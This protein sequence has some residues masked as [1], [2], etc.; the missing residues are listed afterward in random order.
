MDKQNFDNGWVK[1]YHPTGALVTVPLSLE[2][3]LTN[4]A[5]GFLFESVNNLISCGFSV[6]APGVEAGEFVDEIGWVV[7]KNQKNERGVTPRIE[8]YLSNPDLRKKFI[9]FYLNTEEEIFAFEAACGLKLSS[10]PVYVGKDS[11]ERGADADTDKFV[12]RLPKP[13]KFVWR[14][15]P[16]YDPN[17]QDIS[18]KKPRR[19]FVRWMVAA[20]APVT[21]GTSDLEAASATVCHVGNDAS[22]RGKTLGQLIEAGRQDVINFLA[23]DFAANDDAGKKLKNAAIL[24]KRHAEQ[25]QNLSTLGF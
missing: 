12:A 10:L 1:L 7:R 4:A 15:N 22:V 25:K 24:L 11:V 5:A 20:T 17:E 23:D 9:H 16:S 14:E 18:K 8:A 19:L 2:G 6:N 3:V 13:V 21:G